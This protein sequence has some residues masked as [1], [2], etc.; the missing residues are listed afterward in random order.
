MG[1]GL[2]IAIV[3]VI[4]AVVLALAVRIVKQYEQGVQLRLDKL[5]GTPWSTP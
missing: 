5:V 1:T 4:G 2:G 3:V